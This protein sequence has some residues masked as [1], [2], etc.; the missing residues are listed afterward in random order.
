M[1]SWSVLKDFSSSRMS[2]QFRTQNKNRKFHEEYKTLYC[3]F[4]TYFTKELSFSV[5]TL[6]PLIKQCLS[7]IL[8]RKLIRYTTEKNE[9]A[10]YTF[11][12]FGSTF[13]HINITICSNSCRK[14]MQLHYHVWYYLICTWMR[15][16]ILTQNCIREELCILFVAKVVVIQKN[17]NF[18][19]IFSE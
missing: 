14:K 17:K 1:D 5:L 12:R 6:V 3:V 15:F 7:Q 11:C 16:T 8:K 4:L 18:G 19:A 2:L 13:C 10:Q 9:F